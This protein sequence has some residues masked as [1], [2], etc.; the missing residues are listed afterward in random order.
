MACSK[1]PRMIAVPQHKSSEVTP[2]TPSACSDLPVNS[3]L[4]G[5]SGP[6]TTIR[7]A[8]FTNPAVFLDPRDRCLG[9]WLQYLG[10]LR[11]HPFGR[12][13]EA[14]R[15]KAYVHGVLTL[16]FDVFQ[17]ATASPIDIGPG[18]SA[19]RRV[20]KAADRNHSGS[21]AACISVLSVMAYLRSFHPE[22]SRALWLR[23][24]N[25]ETCASGSDYA[26]PRGSLGSTM[27]MGSEPR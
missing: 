23:T 8:E 3:S 16:G 2:I 10:H 5:G 26:Q 27:L 11:R 7:L 20:G 13:G 9:I 21:S 15:A 19:L 1:N 22:S 4:N 14:Q 12:E 17:A 25:I 6:S 24:E 18:R